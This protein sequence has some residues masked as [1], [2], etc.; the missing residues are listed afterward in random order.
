MKFEVRD[1]RV[2]CTI[3]LALYNVDVLHKCFYW[4]AADY[5]VDIDISQTEWAVVSLWPKSSKL[6]SATELESRIRTDLVDFKTRDIIANETKTIREL[7]IA[8]A[9][10]SSDEYE[11]RPPGE[12]SDPVG[13]RK[14]NES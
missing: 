9:F 13:F 14:P 8:K 12:V 3:P 11:Q 1:G 4:Y 10:S 2:V 6:T 7:L 5:G